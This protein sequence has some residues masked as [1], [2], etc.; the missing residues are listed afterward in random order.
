MK[1]S[2]QIAAHGVKVTFVN[3]EPIH[4]KI[5]A[6]TPGIHGKQGLISC[7]SIFDGLELES[8]RND[9]VEFTESTGRVMPGQLMNLIE[10]INQCNTTNKEQIT[11]VIVDVSIGWALEVAKNMGIEGVAV[12]TAGP[13]GL[14]L[15]LCIPQLIKD[16][17]LGDDGTLL[18]GKSISLSS[19]IPAWRKFEIPW[20]TSSDI[21]MQKA[22]FKFVRT[23]LQN[24][25]FAN[26]I[27]SNSFDDLA[28]SA[29]KLTPNILLVGLLLASN[30]LGSFTRSFWP[31]DSTCLSRHDKQDAGSV[32]YVAFG[33]KL[34]LA[35][36]K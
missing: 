36:N 32:I 14:A 8:D 23:G 19:E 27:L 20:I 3:F 11:C 35:H 5:I 33:S 24:F 25:K 29:L 2:L 17:I 12:H 9:A 16:E 18:K 30:H 4:D 13:A 34:S 22:I 10:K 28:P 6:S 7:A 26:L 1:L 15:A 21:I 31:E